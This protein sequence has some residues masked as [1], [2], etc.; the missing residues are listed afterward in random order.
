MRTHC[1]E[2]HAWQKQEVERE[3]VLGNVSLYV[4]EDVGFEA[5]WVNKDGRQG[6]S[7]VSTGKRWAGQRERSSLA[8]VRATSSGGFPLV[9]CDHPKSLLKVNGNISLHIEMIFLK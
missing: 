7:Q 1:T 4:L 3:P 2:G 9:L 5:Q 6:G 8:A